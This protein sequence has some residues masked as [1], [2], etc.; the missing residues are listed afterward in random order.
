M[1]RVNETGLK[2]KATPHIVYWDSVRCREE[3]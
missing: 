1:K 3:Q 2:Q